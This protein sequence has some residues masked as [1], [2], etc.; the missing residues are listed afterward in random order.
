M[1][2]FYSI[3][4]A[5]ILFCFALSV[6]TRQAVAQ[7]PAGVA[8]PAVQNPP[9]PGEHAPSQSYLWWFIRSSGLIGLFILALSIYFVATV[10]RLFLEVRVDVAIPPDLTRRLED[11]QQRNDFQTLY[12]TIQKRTRISVAFWPWDCPNCPMDS[13]RPATR[14][15]VWESLKR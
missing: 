9:V 8:A 1:Q 6:F 2:R 4:I 3:V 5:G 10:I 14:W 15:I 7:E 11:L 12:N 13:P